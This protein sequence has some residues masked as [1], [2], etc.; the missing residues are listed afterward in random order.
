MA[1]RT[2]RMSDTPRS[3]LE[4][5]S[6][7]QVD[8]DRLLY[9]TEFRRLAGVTQVVSP[10][11]GEIFHSRLTH[12]LKVAQ[13]GRRLAESLVNREQNKEIITAWGGLDPDVVES[14]AMAHDLGHPPFGH[15][16]EEELN[17]LIR[18]VV[19]SAEQ[20]PNRPPAP[21]DVKDKRLKEIEGYEGNA[22]SFR[23]ITKLAIRRRASPNAL[24]L[25]R[26]TLNATLKYPRLFAVGEKKY[27][28]FADDR[29]AFEFARVGSVLGG[30]T[31][32]LEAQI[33]DWADDITY[34]VH[35]VEDFY[36]AGLIPLDRLRTNSRETTAFLSRA[37]D[38]RKKQNRPYPIAYDE[39]PGALTALFGDFIDVEA[40]YDGTLDRR[41]HI[42]GVSSDLIKHF[43]GKTSLVSPGTEATSGLD[44]PIDVRTYV[45]L[46]KDLIW[47]YVIENPALAA[48]QHGQ[49][50][51]IRTLF[52]VLYDAIE[53]DQPYLFPAAFQDTARQ[54]PK[55]V[56]AAQKSRLVADAV[57]SLTDQ[58][59]LRLYQRLTAS[60]QGSV[61]DPI[62]R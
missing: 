15:L 3:K 58:Q 16:A 24:D 27:G 49:R 35:D 47:C 6:E 17:G 51:V 5:R 43:L 32:S 30:A 34:S 53:N 57:S 56:P 42:Y 39:A 59:A 52:Q 40:P 12:T 2:D 50:R 55:S 28:A 54:T 14:A 7:S 26:A 1:A 61:L 19:F 21:P 4:T 36:R 25:T 48:H 29:Q 8:R 46:L 44:I 31:R 41:Q 18:E 9:S 37:K 11:E 13:I 60:S 38:R 45:E 23:I 33:M 62:V 20:P 22:Q 10:G